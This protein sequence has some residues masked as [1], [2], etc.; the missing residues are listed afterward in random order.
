MSSESRF[1]GY[2]FGCCAACRAPFLPTDPRLFGY[3]ETQTVYYLVSRFK[4]VSDQA[5]ARSDFT[6]RRVKAHVFSQAHVRPALEFVRGLTRAQL[7]QAVDGWA[8]L[9]RNRDFLQNT[10]R[11][12]TGVR[13][14]RQ[15]GSTATLV[16]FTPEVMDAV[17]RAQES[18]AGGADPDAAN[19]AILRSIANAPA[20]VFQAM[21]DAPDL[22]GVRHSE[23]A[24]WVEGTDI[25]AAEI[26]LDLTLPLCALCNHIWD[27]FARLSLTLR[28]STVV[29]A[30]AVYVKNGAKTMTLPGVGVTD[31]Q[32]LQR[33][34]CSAAYYLHGS[35]RAIGSVVSD[36]AKLEGVRLQVVSALAWL[37]LHCHCVYQEMSGRASGAD[38]VKGAHNYLGCVDLLISYFLYLCA[39]VDPARPFAGYPF[40]RFH[41]FYAKELA[42]CPAPV[43]DQ[44]SYRRVHDYV[45]DDGYRAVMNEGGRIE[46]TSARLASLYQ[47]V[48]QPLLG[49]VLGQPAATV[50]DVAA[51]R[52]FLTHDEADQLV[53]GFLADGA[54]NVD[55]VRVQLERVGI[56]ALLWQLQR[57]MHSESE[58]F[59]REVGLWMKKRMQSEWKNIAANQPGD[60]IGMREAQLVYLLM[61]TRDDL[62]ALPAP[63]SANPEEVLAL[64]A[65]SADD[66][67]TAVEAMRAAGRCSM[68]KAALRLRA[69]KF[70]QEAPA[71]PEP[72]QDEDDDEEEE[73]DEEFVPGRR[74]PGRRPPRGLLSASAEQALALSFAGLRVTPG[75]SRRRT[76]RS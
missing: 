17:R 4:A 19:L 42:E 46:H 36:P 10:F 34:G 11:M 40:E 21:W 69:W 48:V 59:Q 55:N 75:G 27:A 22:P 23:L 44:A 45:F 2:L 39:I 30:G 12:Q 58:R 63:S 16:E 73:D 25:L 74:R 50:H 24:Q 66:P 71:L 76:I 64:A 49:F 65:D 43:W 38:A 6:D 52:F 54:A 3:K 60:S 1:R 47:D 51:E 5:G 31:R 8:P 28:S 57:G 33:L 9:A 72:Y 18:T 67:E 15:A 29:P 26:D 14:T 35:L 7:N 56:S 68:W 37:P 32:Y 53:D 13:R 62:P 41:V 70:T 61:H 20:S